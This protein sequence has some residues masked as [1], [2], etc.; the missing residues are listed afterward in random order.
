MEFPACVVWASPSAFTVFNFL[1]E[2]HSPSG[3]GVNYATSFARPI[4]MLAAFNDALIK[5]V[6][7]VV[8]TD[9]CAFGNATQPGL[10]FAHLQ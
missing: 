2:F 3:E 10:D 8:S 4:L 6:A 5:V 7:T 1:P 9:P